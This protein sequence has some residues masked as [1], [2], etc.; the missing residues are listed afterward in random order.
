MIIGDSGI[1]KTSLINCFLS[2]EGSKPSE[3]TNGVDV[4]FKKLKIKDGLATINVKK[5]L[6]ISFQSGT[7]QE[8]KNI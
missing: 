6:K 2:R 8:K 7:Y 4:F 1:G 5:F 3:P